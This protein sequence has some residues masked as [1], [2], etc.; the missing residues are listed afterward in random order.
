MTHKRG[1]FKVEARTHLTIHLKSHERD[2]ATLLPNTHKYEAKGD[3]LC[4]E[5]LISSDQIQRPPQFA[6]NFLVGRYSMIS[7]PVNCQING[8]VMHAILFSKQKR[9]ESE[10]ARTR[11]RIE[12]QLHHFFNLEQALH[13]DDRSKRR[14]NTTVEQQI[15]SYRAGQA[16]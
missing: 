6:E 14:Q 5:T 7:R 11:R 4:P 9:C 15:A 16:K 2:F 13:D 10:E 8:C 3:P 1:L 12:G